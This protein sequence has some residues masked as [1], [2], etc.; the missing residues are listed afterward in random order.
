[1][2][3]TNDSTAI[4]RPAQG[5]ALAVELPPAHV[6]DLAAFSFYLPE[7]AGLEITGGTAQLEASLN[8]SATTRSGDG[9]LRLS[10][11]QVAAAF[12]EVDLRADVLLDSRLTDARLEDGHIDLSGT[13]LEI[14]EVRTM[15]QGRCATAAGGGGSRFP[16][17]G[18]S[19]PSAIRPSAPAR[20]E[21][22]VSAE[23][24]DTGPLVAL[25]QQHLPGCRGW[26]AC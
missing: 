25:L 17:A 13:R 10:G 2:I 20:I 16:G 21:A 15:E 23:L 8:Y 4:D 3:V 6:P 7:A 9:R 1:M 22:D 11:H 14:D 24:R 26:T 18:W 12:H 5:I 19:R